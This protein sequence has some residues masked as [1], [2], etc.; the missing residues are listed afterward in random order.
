MEKN[1]DNFSPFSDPQVR[2]KQQITAR[3]SFKAFNSV[4]KIFLEGLR[5]LFPND[6]VLRLITQEFTG[7]IDPERRPPQIKTPAL[8]FFREMRKKITLPDETVCD[9]IDVLARHDEYAFENP[10]VAMLRGID[11]SAKW[12]AMSEDEKEWC[13][14]YLDKLIHLSTQ[15]RYSSSNAVEEMNTL[16]RSVV[17]AAIAGKNTPEEMVSDPKVKEAALSFIKTI[18]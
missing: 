9:Y 11:M 12:K 8:N 6:A 18:K 7:L 13:W 16:S 14:E 1:V 4:A 3:A 2:R 5:R 10:P 17:G 15:A